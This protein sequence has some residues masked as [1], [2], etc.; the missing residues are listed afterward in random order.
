MGKAKFWA[1]SKAREVAE[2]E[3]YHYLE[4]KVP[5]RD[6]YVVKSSASL[7]GAL[8]IGR[9]S[10][11]IRADSVCIALGEAGFEA[12]LIWVAEDMDPLRKVPRGVPESFEEYIGMPVSRVPDPWGCHESYARH[13]TSGFFNVLKEFVSTEPR[14]YS[15]RKEYSKGSFKPFIEKMMEERERVIEIQNRH[16]KKPLP[17]YYSPFAPLCKGCGKIITPSVKSFSNGRV[18]YRCDDYSFEEHTARGCGY[19]GSA[20]PL[21]DG[22]KLMWKGEWAAQW[23]RWKVSCEGA[24]KEY[25]VPAS[26]WWVNAEIAEKVLDYPM[27]VPVFYEHLMIDGEKM[28]A[29]LGNVVYPE[30]WLE[31]APPQLLRF[32]YN[33][34]LLKTRSFSWRELPMLYDEYDKHARVSFGYEAPGSKKESRQMSRLY[35]ISQL[36]EPQKPSPLPF[37]H[38]VMLASL[39]K[40]R[41]SLVSS[42]KR[43]GHYARELEGDILARVG[44]AGRWLGSY[45]PEKMKFTLLEELGE[46]EGKLSREQRKFLGELGKA[47]EENVLSGEELQQ[48][49]YELAGDIKLSPKKAFQSI[50]L[51][52][53]GSRYGP[54]AGAFLSSLPRE[55]IAGRLREAGL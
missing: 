42:L 54:K 53:L 43:S 48:M 32:F 7:S 49:I 34:K 25:V 24:G 21:K 22:G 14:Q 12:E 39:Y 19:E 31:V 29:S 2:R 30:E 17:R 23:A 11:T 51:V 38:A 41:D 47:M 18:H 5:D 4:K 40:G 26:A 3:W 33:K 35:Q 52:T 1:D 44:Y 55:W 6:K 9:L 36:G 37:S 45:A 10:D 16:R 13:Y 8:H 50:Y 20:S 27:P 28:S 46:V 15:M